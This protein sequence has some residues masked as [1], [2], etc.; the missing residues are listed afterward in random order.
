MKIS[1]HCYF[2]PGLSHSDCFTVNAG[3]ITSQ[4]ETI[5]VDSGFNK[6]SA[7]T[8]FSYAQA[9][10]PGNKISHV[11]NLE[12]H[13][14]H[15]FGNAFLRK[16]G[17][18]IVAHLETFLTQKDLDAFI[19]EANDEISID[20]RRRNNEAYIFFDGVEPFRPDVPISEDRTFHFHG[21]EIVAL[22]APG[23]T[24]SNVMVYVPDD[25]VLYAGDTIYSRYLPTLTFGNPELWTSWLKTLDLIAEIAPRWIVPGHGPL[26]EDE[27]IDKELVRH[28]EFI[29]NKLS[30][31]RTL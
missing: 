26:V 8:L 3:F 19:K 20:L 23:H 16:K 29:K 1:P 22:M 28:R 27:Q 14:D 7:V 17:V 15:V 13:Y 12:A 11:I 25:R 10:Q 2:V 4:R 21:L 24:S 30:K 9:V 5:L 6:D 18:K 31:A